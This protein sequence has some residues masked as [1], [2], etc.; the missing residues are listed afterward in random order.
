MKTFHRAIV[1][2]VICLTFAAL[3]SVSATPAV[4]DE[5][6]GWHSHGGGEWHHHG[7][8]GE[9]HGDWHRGWGG[10]RDGWGGGWRGYGWDGYYAPPY[11]G[12]NGYAPGYP[13][14]PPAIIYPPY[15]GYGGW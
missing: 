1:A 14:A 8:G 12:W 11:L 2:I 10:W 13:Y 9:R 4:A 3:A 15:Y 7:W 6:G 5:H